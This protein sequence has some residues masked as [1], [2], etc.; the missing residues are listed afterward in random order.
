MIKSLIFLLAVMSSVFSQENIAVLDLDADGVTA[1]EAKTLTNKL[2]GEL[3]NTG[4]FT[5]IERG[6][7]DN[8]LKEQG[9]QSTGCTSQ[10]CAVEMGQ[11][12][13]V[14]KMI[15]GGIGKVGN[16]Y[17]ISL[18]IIDV[19]KGTILKNVDEEVEGDIAAVLRTGL[20]NSARK[21]AGL[22]ADKSYNA[23]PVVPEPSIT[24]PQAAITRR[25]VET[26]PHIE[27]AQPKR[28]ENSRRLLTFDVG[29]NSYVG[30]KFSWNEEARFN[31]TYSD[32]EWKSGIHLGI[33]V[34]MKNI[35][36]K[37]EGQSSF[38]IG[39]GDL[40][41]SYERNTTTEQILS[42]YDSNGALTDFYPATDSTL[43]Y[44]RVTL[45][46]N[47]TVAYRIV[48]KPVEIEPYAGVGLTVDFG[49]LS[50]ELIETKIESSLLKLVPRLSI[51]LGLRFYMGKVFL[52]FE[53]AFTTGVLRTATDPEWN[54]L[55]KT[56]INGDLSFEE[57]SVWAFQLGFIV[58]N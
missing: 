51:P 5:V 9:F 10:E 54:S 26:A 2:R 8:I 38:M 45:Y 43:I 35:Y 15:A 44:N 28:I 12:L 14:E 58:G 4:Q 1:S 3:I 23:T 56:Y 6:E 55:T 13:G 48:A 37:P 19:R 27:A 24:P 11:L 29:S 25:T 47:I 41:L 31:D 17:L 30:K 52:G 40:G 34:S 32:I 18:R 53:Y 50:G 57:A 22:N 39:C 21:I 16:I 42:V 46:D 7:M 36:F 20:Y 49:V 33:R